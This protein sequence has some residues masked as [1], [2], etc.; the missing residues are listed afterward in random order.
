MPRLAAA[1][2]AAR[3]GFR[4]PGYLISG[5]GLYVWGADMDAAHRH[6]EAF[7]HLFHLTWLSR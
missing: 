1:V 3:A 2:D 6:L 4:V 7:E 5:H